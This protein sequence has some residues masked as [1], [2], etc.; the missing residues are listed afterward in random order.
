MK[1]WSCCF[2]SS[3]KLIIPISY[4]MK[5][6]SKVWLTTLFCS[7]SVS[8]FPFLLHFFEVYQLCM[9][10]IWMNKNR[11]LN[12]SIFIFKPKQSSWLYNFHYISFSLELSIIF[13]LMTRLGSVW[14]VIRKTKKFPE[15]KFDQYAVSQ[16]RSWKDHL[17]AVKKSI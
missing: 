10:R 5:F 7:G 11:V 3:N 9:S 16:V 15:K 12:H 2:K 6:I 4:A 17:I 14:Y 13:F 8:D 1:L